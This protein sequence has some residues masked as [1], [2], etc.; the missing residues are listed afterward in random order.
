MFSFQDK[1]SI[2]KAKYLL[3]LSES[4]LLMEIWDDEDENG[5]K[6]KMNKNEYL[7]RFT[8][9][10]KFMLSCGGQSYKEYKYSKNLVNDGRLYVKTFG[11]QTLKKRIRGFLASDFYND[12]DMSNAHPTILLHL[13][14][15]YIP[16]KKTPYLRKYVNER[17]FFLSKGV[18]KND[19]LIAMNKAKPMITSNHFLEG[20]DKEFKD[21]QRILYDE[22]P[23]ELKGFEHYKGLN[24]KNVK[25]SF[26]NILC[27]IFEKRIL[28][29]AV[30]QFNESQVGAL[31][32]DGLFIDKNLNEKEVIDKLNN[33]SSMYGVKWIKKKHDD[34]IEIDEGIEILDDFGLVKTYANIKE[35]F[36][37]T[38]LMIKSPLIFIQEDTYKDKKTYNLYGKEDFKTL[39]APYTI[40]IK[41]KE[42]PFI[43]EWLKDS[44]KRLYKQIDFIPSYDNVSDETFNTF[45]GFDY[46]DYPITSSKHPA[47]DKYI[48]HMKILVNN[49]EQS[50]QYLINYIAHMIQKTTELPAVAILLK[51]KQGFG[52]DTFLDVIQ[53]MMGQKYFYRTADL[54]EV[55]GSF[56]TSLKHKLILQLNELEGKNG[57]H[58]KEKIKNLITEEY[59]NLN[60][61]NIK[62]YKQTNYI[63]LFICSNN[64]TPI[65]IPHD[66]RRFV[67]F[68]SQRQK[69]DKSYFQ[70]IRNTIINNDEAVFAL[71]EYFNTIDI[72]NF[73][74]RN[75]RPLTDAYKEMKDAEINPLYTY[76]Y[77]N[78]NDDTYK[79]EF[80]NKY[81]QHKV[82]KDI[83][84]YSDDLLDS[85]KNYLSIKD[86]TYIKISYKLLKLLLSNIGIINKQI[87]IGTE[88]IKVY[89]INKTLIK[90][91]EDEMGLQEDIEVFNDDDFE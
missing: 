39:T 41:D 74:I 40:D 76:L 83:Y 78:F 15:K 60:E 66:D 82:T 75:D 24:K 86:I 73:D 31:M 54:N 23:E 58:D 13:V 48:S 72:S 8:K 14:S 53:K 89:V 5:E 28:L 63:R 12:Y 65:E 59:T 18:A 29:N 21:I 36:E 57:F 32:F 30:K 10:L 90:Q 3:S 61:K 6:F 22:T 44:N 26:L 68:K 51:S 27:C 34:S 85:Y 52:K 91:L 55:F 7:I 71:Y 81:K 4:R 38:H 69:P 70:D 45:T 25:G 88:R 49:C 42:V 50:T 20:I 77:E 46:S 11:I 64:L 47:I 1:I 43:N 84:V 16:S 33:S 80:E 19:V 79:I 17:D 9:Y 67:V 56:N 62:S 37:K 35:D 2:N 87:R